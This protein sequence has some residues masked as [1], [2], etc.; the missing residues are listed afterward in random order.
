MRTHI[1]RI[2]NSQRPPCVLALM[3]RF[4]EPQAGPKNRGLASSDFPNVV[5]LWALCQSFREDVYTGL[6]YLSIISLG[7][8]RIIIIVQP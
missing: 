5:F 4:W 8:L 6:A 1:E 2:P 3:G 7:I